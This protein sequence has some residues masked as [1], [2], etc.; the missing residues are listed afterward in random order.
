MTE[1]G[2]YEEVGPLRENKMKI[3]RLLHELIISVPKA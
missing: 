1:W 3:D 2:N